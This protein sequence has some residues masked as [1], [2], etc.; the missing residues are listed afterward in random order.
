V[1]DAIET[2]NP[3]LFAA[4]RCDRDPSEAVGEYQAGSLA[5]GVNLPDSGP[6]YE[7]WLGTDP[8]DADDWGDLA[9]LQCVEAVGREL[10]AVGV[11]LHVGD[12]SKKPG[13][14]FFPHKTHQNGLEVDVHYPRK[15]GAPLPLDIFVDQQKIDLA[16]T[17]DLFEIFARSCDV[18][19]IFA[20]SDQ[21]DFSL[22]EPGLPMVI[23][24]PTRR[25]EFLVR[26]RKPSGKAPGDP[27]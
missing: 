13:G 25:S 21:L 20:P 11:T 22:E 3:G 5:G 6:G 15:D 19:A 14:P 9:L 7:H 1:S 23:D 12:L 27:R 24:Q 18:A 17:R 16:A 2:A 8:N 4:G 10:A 26:L